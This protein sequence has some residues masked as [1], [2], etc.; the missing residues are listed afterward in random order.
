MP[1]LRISFGR[2]WIGDGVGQTG[3]LR[4]FP[5]QGTSERG[6]ERLWV[7][8]TARGAVAA[9]NLELLGALSERPQIGGPDLPSGA[10][11]D[12]H[13]RAARSRIGHQTQHRGDVG[14]L[15][16]MQQSAEP[17]HLDG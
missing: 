9:P 12:T 7:V 11:E 1:G 13:G 4:L 3:L 15:R 2:T 6:V 14:D 5:R 17:D 8:D 16:H 10:R